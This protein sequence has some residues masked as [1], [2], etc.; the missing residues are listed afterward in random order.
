MESNI[1]AIDPGA[2]G[3]AAFFSNGG[4]VQVQAFGGNLADMKTLLDF[5][6]YRNTEKA[7]VENVHAMKRDG[8][9]SAFSFGRRKAEVELTLYLAG[10]E[11]VLVDVQTW[12]KLLGLPK[13]YEI[14]DEKKRRAARR[15][16]QEDLAKALYPALCDYEADIWA[17]VLIGYSQLIKEDENLKQW[18]MQCRRELGW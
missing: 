10:A 15:K 4:L 13:R 1:A 7:F 9:K 5:L 3:S 12:P 16:D 8:K 2:T 6:K 18:L 14:S 11:M 17:S